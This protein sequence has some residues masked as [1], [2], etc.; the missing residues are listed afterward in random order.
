MFSEEDKKKLYNILSKVVENTNIER[1]KQEQVLK[2]NM[3][4][5]EEKV[6]YN[7][8]DIDRHSK[9]LCD[10]CNCSD[11]E[12][13]EDNDDEY[14]CDGICNYSSGYEDDVIY[15][16][17]CD[18]LDIK[19]LDECKDIMLEMLIEETLP[20]LGLTYTSGQFIFDDKKYLISINIEY[21]FFESSIFDNV[22]E[23]K[24]ICILFCKEI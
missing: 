22:F 4:S 14:D 15:N 19:S 23:I 11:N 17:D 13:S 9:W 24:N 2:E 21:D 12:E 6:K 10:M 3:I 7:I 18:E 1:V 8:D 20:T 5:E 16:F